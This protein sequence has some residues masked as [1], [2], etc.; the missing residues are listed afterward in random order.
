MIRMCIGIHGKE[1][2]EVA[3]FN[4]LLCEKCEAE[5][6]EACKKAHQ[7]AQKRCSGALRKNIGKGGHE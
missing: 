4:S 3:L 6:K 7:E 1:C 2:T 5:Y